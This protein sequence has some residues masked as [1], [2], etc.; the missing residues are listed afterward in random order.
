MNP[1]D[2]IILLICSGVF[3]AV[4]GAYFGT[5]E[6][7]I[8]TGGKL[9]SSRCFCPVCGHELSLLH[10]IPVISWIAL[11]GRCHYCQSPISIRYPLSEG[12]FTLYYVTAFLFL[13]HNPL[14]LM[15]AWYLF[16]ALLLFIRCHGHWKAFARGALIMLFFHLIFC[17]LIAVILVTA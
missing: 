6:Y 10:Q 14:S 13:Y 3:G 9:I 1:S 7:R 2:L 16:T 11:K 8:R 4:I 17:P 15:I 5:I 12:G